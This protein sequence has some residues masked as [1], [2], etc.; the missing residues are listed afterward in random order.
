[1]VLLPFPRIEQEETFPLFHD[2]AVGAMAVDP[3]QG[4]P[5]PGRFGAGEAWESLRLLYVALTRACHAVYVGVPEAK[6]E[7]SEAAQQGSALAHALGLQGLAPKA[8]AEATRCRGLGPGNFSMAQRLLALRKPRGK[9]GTLAPA[10]VIAPRSF[11][12]RRG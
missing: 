12:G 4:A 6:G 8:W 7:K 5:V 1:M 9:G 3:A 10:K 11:P 2:P